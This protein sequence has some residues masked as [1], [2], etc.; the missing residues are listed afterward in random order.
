MSNEKMMLLVLTA[1][2]I[3]HFFCDFPL[4]TFYMLGKGKPGTAWI[5]PLA[6][7]CGVHAFFTAIIFLLYS[8][9]F[10]WLSLLEFAIHFVVDRAKATYKL[11]TG[12]WTPEQRGINLTKYYR[13]F[14][15]DQLAHGLTYIALV[16][17][18]I[19]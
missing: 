11:D 6:A 9:S 8:P 10:V 16:Y 3:K 5:A 4:Q 2:A 15:L 18:S 14:G 13:A 12:V 19:C 17:I 1:F 7:H